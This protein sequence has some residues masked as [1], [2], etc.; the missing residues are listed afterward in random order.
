[1]KGGHDHTTL[2]PSFEGEIGDDNQSKF[3]SD[4]TKN[5]EFIVPKRKITGLT[6]S[7]L[8]LSALCHLYDILE[9]CELLNVPVLLDFCHL[10]V[11]KNVFID[12]KKYSCI[13]TLAFS[14][15]KTCPISIFGPIFFTAYF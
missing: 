1:M 7:Q 11:S 8:G 13:E 4:T 9:Q 12:L 3:N 6:H 2:Q 14:F 10:P 5:L 15:S